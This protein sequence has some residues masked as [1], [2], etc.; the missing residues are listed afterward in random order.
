MKKIVVI[1][2]VILMA[3]FLLQSKKTNNH[4][5]IAENYPW[6]IKILANGQTRIF[7]VV[8]GENKL[9]DVDVI[10][11]STPKVALF[12]SK[13]K[14]VLEAFYKDIPLGVLSGSFIFTLDVPSDQLKKIKN[15]SIKQEPAGNNS[16]RYQL[17]K[18]MLEASKSYVI[19]DLIYIPT[20]QLDEDMIIK[21]FGKPTYKIKLKTKEIGW[22]YLYPE[23]GLDLIYKQD[24]KEVLQYVI[25][26]RFNLL[27][28]PLQSH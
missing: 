9:K 24:D 12:E 14:L 2:V 5:R 7:G 6:Q 15:K 4:S 26:K 17:D 21:R 18:Y 19:N 3:F 8:L 13:D 23:K 20:V 27:L 1:L 22:H 10:L 25:P 11:N 28:E 16:K